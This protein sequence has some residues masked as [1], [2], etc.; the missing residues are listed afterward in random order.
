[1]AEFRFAAVLIRAC[2]ES[3]GNN[4]SKTHRFDALG[5]P[6]K[7]TSARPKHAEANSERNLY[8]PL[9]GLGYA[10]WPIDKTPICVLLPGR[11]VIIF[12]LTWQD[13]TV[14]PPSI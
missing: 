2:T 11:L 9:R 13:F 3:N 8:D 7:K 6:Q 1:M 14:E 10:L 4:S 12:N 5:I